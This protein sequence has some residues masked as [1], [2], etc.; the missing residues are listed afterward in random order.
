MSTA[1]KTCPCCHESFE[2][3]SLRRDGHVC[4]PSCGRIFPLQAAPPQTQ[5]FVAKGK[6]RWG[7]LSL[8]ELRRMAALHDLAPA[9]MVLPVGATKWVEAASLTDVFPRSTGG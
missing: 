6:H 2:A 4:C 3:T 1:C 7:P 8:D 5:W 9:D